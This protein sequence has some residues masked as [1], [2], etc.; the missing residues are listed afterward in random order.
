MFYESCVEPA[1]L[2]STFTTRHFLSLTPVLSRDIEAAPFASPLPEKLA[3]ELG[4]GTVKPLSKYVHTAVDCSSCA[5]W[6]RVWAPSA[7]E[8][9]VVLFS[10]ADP[11]WSS[12]CGHGSV[13]GHAI[14]RIIGRYRLLRESSHPA[15]S[16]VPG[17]LPTTVIGR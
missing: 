1:A 10:S 17:L 16:A 2:A 5:S 14:C 7:L 9:Y 12:E 6:F 11:A 15:L 4:S 8:V 13:G 3:N